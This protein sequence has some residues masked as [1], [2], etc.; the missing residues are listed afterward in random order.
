MAVLLA[1]IGLV[2]TPSAA[3]AQETGTV[4]VPAGSH[5][6]LVVAGGDTLVQGTTETVV[7]LTGDVTVAG[8]VRGVAIAVDGQV[9]VLPGGRVEGDAYSSSQPMVEAGGVVTGVTDRIDARRAI[10]LTDRS[11]GLLWW[12]ATTIALLALGTLL[13]MAL[14]RVFDLTVATGTAEVGPAAITGLLLAIGL[15]VLAIFLAITVVGIPLA[16][17]VILLLV[18][19]YVLGQLAAAWI[20]GVL[21]QRR[22]DR[23]VLALITG[24]WLLQI[25]SAVPV[26][27]VLSGLASAYGLGALAIVTWRGARTAAKSATTPPALTT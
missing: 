10:E 20:V 19:L 7:A 6:G 8:T 23:R 4:I 12:V 21:V 22:R 14:P 25:V 3:L 26:L 15:P 18:P 1:V 13:T 5:A 9:R 27:G 11:V 24:V 2:T 16:L 17:A